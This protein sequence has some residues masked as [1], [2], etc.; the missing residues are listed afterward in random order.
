MGPKQYENRDLLG[1]GKGLQKGRWVLDFLSPQERSRLMSRIKSKDTRPEWLVRRLVYSMGYR[2]RLHRR[3]LA[4]CPDLVFASRRRIIFVH[5][6]FW[7]RHEGCKFASMP[8]TRTEFWHKKFQ[9]NV[10]RDIRVRGELSNAGWKVML[11]WQ[12][13][14]LM[15]EKLAETL[16]RFLEGECE[17][18]SSSRFKSRNVCLS[19]DNL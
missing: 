7:H 13:E 17:E 9:D 8:K 4:G 2:Y 3:D 14:T 5:G 11:V 15:P 6:C 12:C 19:R 18:R 10:A 1:R 16:E